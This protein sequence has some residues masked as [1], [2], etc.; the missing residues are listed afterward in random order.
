MTPQY[1]HN[2][3]KIFHKDGCEFCKIDNQRCDGE[4]CEYF[5]EMILI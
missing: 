5:K 2:C 4:E 3:P 1:Y